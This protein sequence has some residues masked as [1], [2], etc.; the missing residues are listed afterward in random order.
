MS[1]VY[2]VSERVVHLLAG[3]LT[4]LSTRGAPTYPSVR[5]LAIAAADA[6]DLGVRTIER[7]LKDDR[8]TD[9]LAHLVGP[10][11]APAAPTDANPQV[12]ALAQAPVPGDR[13]TLLLGTL[14][15]S[16]PRADPRFYKRLKPNEFAG[17]CTEITCSRWVDP[18]EGSYLCPYPDGSQVPLLC[19]EHALI[20]D[21]ELALSAVST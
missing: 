4:A 5:Q 18:F 21:V 10:V 20:A 8:L 15:L 13:T 11:G 12:A 19:S 16:S 17:Q 9:L 3:Y 14:R 2:G 1:G 6:L 7:A